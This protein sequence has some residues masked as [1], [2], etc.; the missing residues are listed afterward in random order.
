MRLSHFDTWAASFIGVGL[1]LYACGPDTN[2]SETLR[3]LPENPHYFL[4]HDKPTVIVGSGE[5]YGAVMNLDFDYHTY[6]ATLDADGLN[7]TRLFAGAYVER[8]GDFGIAKNTLAPGPGRVTLPWQRSNENGYE[9]GGNKFDLS[10]WDTAYFSR[11]VDFVATARSYDIIVEVDLFS[12]YYRNGWSYSALNPHNNI[13]GTD[14]IISTSVNTL[15]NGNLIQYQEAYVRKIVQTL[16]AFDNLYYEIQ[17]EPWADQTDTVYVVDEHRPK[18]DWRNTVQVATQEALEWQRR[19]T[20]WIDDEEN[21]LPVKH[22]ISQNVANFHCPVVNPDPAVDIFNFHYALPI[23]VN[24]NYHLKKVVGLNETGFAGR[25][26]LTYRQ[27]AWKFMMS[28]GGLYNH[29][30]YS[31]SVGNEDGTDTTYRAPGGGSV[32]L[33]K[34]LAVMKHFLEQF[35]LSSLH[36]DTTKIIRAQKGTRTYTLRDS[37]SKWAVYLLCTQD[38]TSVTLVQSLTNPAIT[39]TDVITGEQKHLTVTSD[40]HLDIPDGATELALLIEQE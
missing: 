39:W 38:T 34:Q 17:N 15:N 6:L 16:K 30:D 23:A 20:A 5:H 25:A 18:E 3:L 37:H 19:V 36:P 21:G 11:L 12:S 1:L 32:A 9:L 4:Y 10:R 27:Q 31:F 26:D 8:A 13:N 7:T 28:G 33:R 2:S 14:S 24:E 22:L 29:L 40:G 35:D